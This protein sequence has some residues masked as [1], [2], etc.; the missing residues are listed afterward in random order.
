MWTWHKA[1]F[2]P[3]VLSFFQ[4]YLVGRKTSYYWNNFSSSFHIDVRIEQGSV[5]SLVLF[6][7]YLFPLFYIF[8]KW[9]KNLNI[10]VSIFLFMDNRLFIAQDKSITCSNSNLFRSYNI[11]TS[12]LKRF[13]LVVEHRKTEVFH[14][15]RLHSMFNP[16]PLNLSTVEG[17]ILQP[18]NS[19]K[20]LGFFFN[21]KLTFQQYVDFYTNKAYSTI[22]CM[23][24]LG[25]S[26]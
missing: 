23:K 4:D 24:M 11:M 18:K 6:T 25:N 19:W 26:S 10:T 21:R 9:L 17:L 1:S 12:I 13:C 2:D 3:K 20:Y 14:F 22:K 15:S 8:E 5:L 16:P 7:L